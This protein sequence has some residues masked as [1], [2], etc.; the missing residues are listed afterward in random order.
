MPYQIIPS[1]W[2]DNETELWIIC[3]P[4]SRQWRHAIVN[5][6]RSLTRGRFWDGDTGNIVATQAIAREIV[7]SMTTCDDLINKLD[8]LVTAIG[9]QNIVLT[10]TTGCCDTTQPPVP[11]TPPPIT[12][13]P[14][15]TP[16]PPPA[17]STEDEYRNEICRL[18][19]GLHWQ[20]KMF[21]RFLGGLDTVAAIIS[22]VVALLAIVFPEPA[23]TI[24]GTATLASIVAFMILVEGGL[25]AVAAWAEQVEPLWDTQQED[26]VCVVYHLVGS[27]TNWLNSLE[28][29]ILYRFNS[30]AVSIPNGLTIERAFLWLEHYI[31][32][33]NKELYELAGNVPSHETPIDCQVCE[34]VLWLWDFTDQL[35][36][37]WV[38]HGINLDVSGQFMYLKP[39][40]AQG[41]KWASVTAD[42]ANTYF[43][44]P[45]GDYVGSVMAFQIYV[46]E[47]AAEIQNAEMWV[48]HT[49]KDAVRTQVYHS[50]LTNH[51]KNEWHGVNFALPPT[52]L[53]RASDCLE[54]V[55]NR[56]DDDWSG[57]SHVR[58]D[59]ISVE[60][61]QVQ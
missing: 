27:S 56:R 39:D 7:D 41:D 49:D 15:S 2:T 61:T 51:V 47:V 29:E 3:A 36:G 32:W 16:E 4:A 17:Y 58:V 35:Y 45:L 20:I 19:N 18:A 59:N 55:I 30:M 38:N 22:I 57:G 50:Y 11:V 1:D 44:K 37:G 42:A 26:F 24:I 28:S 5:A 54:I 31:S 34:D 48:Y 12:L 43:G 21:L 23:T 46:F 40:S 33:W 14:P 25:S 9:N 13:P 8:D 53:R 10:V 60:E 52:V 6:V